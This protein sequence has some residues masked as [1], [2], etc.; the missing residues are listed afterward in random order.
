[1]P[2]IISCLWQYKKDYTSYTLRSNTEKKEPYESPLRLKIALTGKPKK[3]N[4]LYVPS[5]A[6][7]HKIKMRSIIHV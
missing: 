6:D 4:N 1:M 7:V 5:V 3:L 2:I